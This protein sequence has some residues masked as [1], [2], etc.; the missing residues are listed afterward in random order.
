M[1][2]FRERVQNVLFPTITQERKIVKGQCKAKFPTASYL[3]LTWPTDNTLIVA[4]STNI[5]EEGS[6]GL[7]WSHVT[8]NSE[9]IFMRK[10]QIKKPNSQIL[11]FLLLIFRCFLRVLPFPTSKYGAFHTIFLNLPCK[12]TLQ[13]RLKYNLIY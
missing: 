5:S 2:Y 6:K 4:H 8:Q 11:F 12:V 7:L 1:K 13:Q 10:I 9:T 3:A